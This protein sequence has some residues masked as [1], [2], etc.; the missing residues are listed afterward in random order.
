MELLYPKITNVIIRKQQLDKYKTNKSP[1]E[2]EKIKLDY[3]KAIEEKDY[4]VKKLDS[5]I[6]KEK[7]IAKE[8]L[9]NLISTF[10]EKEK[11]FETVGLQS[12]PQN[13]NDGNVAEM[14]RWQ[15]LKDENMAEKEYFMRDAYDKVIEVGGDIAQPNVPKSNI[16]LSSTQ[17]QELLLYYQT[18]AKATKT[19]QDKKEFL[20][21]LEETQKNIIK[22][23]KNNLSGKINI[24]RA[25][26][27]MDEAVIEKN[28]AMRE[29]IRA[30]R[31]KEILTKKELKKAIEIAQEKQAVVQLKQKK[32][33]EQKKNYNN[34]LNQLKSPGNKNIALLNQSLSEIKNYIDNPT[35]LSI[36]QL[37]LEE[38]NQD[39]E[40]FY[41]KNKKP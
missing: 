5:L 7:I 28:K 10:H 6:K 20:F 25:I 22:T 36:A 18:L 31:E 2:I 9:R 29:L 30:I 33:I 3:K 40:K 34:I 32:I 35:D 39:V 21:R 19:L 4:E 12:N 14:E 37:E 8:N 26:I 41:K 15:K 13:K 11:E 24:E 38:A 17:K 27:A 1:E 23:E 16:N